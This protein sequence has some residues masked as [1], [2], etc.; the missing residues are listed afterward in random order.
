MAA[1]T[2]C[3]SFTMVIEAMQQWRRRSHVI[4]SCLHLLLQRSRNRGKEEVRH[5]K[6]ERVWIALTG[7]ST[8][9]NKEQ[10]PHESKV[11][12]HALLSPTITAPI[13]FPAPSRDLLFMGQYLIQWLVSFPLEFRILV[14]SL[15]HIQLF[16][17]QCK[18]PIPQVA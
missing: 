9:N 13:L 5:G 14:A 12:S 18:L 15:L 11:L 3:F 10:V 8:L 7:G 4:A 1:S 2:A 16:S 6:R 17:Y